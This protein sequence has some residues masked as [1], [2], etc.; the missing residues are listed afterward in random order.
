MNLK[1]SSI[2]QLVYFL[3]AN[4]KHKIAEAI[5]IKRMETI[6]HTSSEADFQAK[7]KWLSG[8]GLASEMQELIGKRKNA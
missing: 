8:Q 5:K 2:D 4:E 3:I 1:T 7:L 6:N